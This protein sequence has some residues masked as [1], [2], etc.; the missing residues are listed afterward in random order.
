MDRYHH[1]V[2]IVQTDSLHLDL[3]S[4][5]KRPPGHIELLEVELLTDICVYHPLLLFHDIQLVSYRLGAYP[6][7]QES[8]RR[9]MAL[10]TE[11]VAAEDRTKI[12]RKA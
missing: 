12:G 9:N 5:W 2:E 7:C 10:Q 4:S 6:T 8:G 1:A 3:L 11:L